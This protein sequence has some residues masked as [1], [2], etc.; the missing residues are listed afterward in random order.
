MNSFFWTPVPPAS[1]FKSP[2]PKKS[3]LIKKHLPPPN[4]NPNPNP[5]RTP[6]PNPQPPTPN[7]QPRPP[8]QPQPQPQPRTPTPNP[9]PNPG[10]TKSLRFLQALNAERLEFQF[11][12]CI[13]ALF[14]LLETSRAIPG[15]PGG[16]CSSTRET[17]LFFRQK[18]HQWPSS[19]MARIHFQRSPSIFSAKK[20]SRP[21]PSISPRCLTPSRAT[22]SVWR[23]PTRRGPEGLE[24]PE[25]SGE[26]SEGVLKD[27][28]P[29][30]WLLLG[31][32]L[33][34]AIFWL[35]GGNPNPLNC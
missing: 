5:T 18:G 1:H 26:R 16:S 24:G 23:T 29:V 20:D 32:I 21:S 15:L 33:H 8:P 12:R 4:P 22:S 17:H 2:P 27:R 3:S 7:P 35:S 28:V 11:A 31:N 9:T 6:N 19:T 30:P 13:G 34:F 10:P 25:E 14:G